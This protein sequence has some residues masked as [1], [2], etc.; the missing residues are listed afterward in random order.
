[1][2]VQFFFSKI[3]LVKVRVG[4][5]RLNASPT[6]KN[7][8]MIVVS[9]HRMSRT[10]SGNISAHSNFSESTLRSQGQRDG[11]QIVSIVSSKASENVEVV[12]E[13]DAA[14]FCSRGD[15]LIQKRAPSIG[16]EIERP[17]FVLDL[18]DQVVV[19]EIASEDDHL[20]VMF[21]VCC[22]RVVVVDGGTIQGGRMIMSRMG[23]S[24]EGSNRKE[25]E[26]LSFPRSI[27]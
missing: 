26:E 18:L 17:E 1:M 22:F 13:D 15:I 27:S 5:S 19:T 12:F 10:R 6:A 7:V 9:N 16:L 8:H 3:E 25:R 4:V 14:V 20:G 2:R 23:D 21:G 11:E 24:V